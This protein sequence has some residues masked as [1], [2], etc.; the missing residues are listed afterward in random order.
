M[1][2]FKNLTIQDDFMFAKV[3]TANLELT[4]KAI[5]VITGRK[6]EDIQFHKAQYTSNPILKLKVQDLMYCLKEMMFV[7]T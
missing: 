4:K 5:E 6:V 7:T 3:M 2:Q 1:K